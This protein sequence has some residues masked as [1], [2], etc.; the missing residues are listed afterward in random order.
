MIQR[1]IYPIQT[2]EQLE[3][4]LLNWR[5]GDPDGEYDFIGIATLL[6]ACVENIRTHALGA[7]ID[8]L[9]EAGFEFFTPEQKT[10]LNRLVS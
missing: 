9:R 10:I 6:K 8:S 5:Q 1:S 4:A 7:E 3:E 2:Y